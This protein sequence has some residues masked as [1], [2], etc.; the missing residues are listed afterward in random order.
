M[1][2]QNP[3][4]R[5]LPLA[6]AT[7]AL[8]LFTLGRTQAASWITN[9]PLTN[10]RYRQTTTLL[11]NGKVL[12]AG[13]T[14]ASVVTNTAELFDPAT[15]IWLPTGSLHSPRSDHTAALLQDGKVLVVGGR[16]GS[17]AAEL[18]S[19]E[20]YDPATGTWTATGPLGTRR[21]GHSATLLR[22]GKVLV[23]GGSYLFSGQVAYV[24][25]AEVYDPVTGNWT[26]TDAMATARS[27]HTMTL[28]PNGKVLVTGGS[29]SGVTLATAELFDP[30]TGDWT[31][32]GPLN[33]ARSSFTTT[34]LP[35]GQVLAAGGSGSSARPTSELYDPASGTWT[36]TGALTVPRGYHTA[37]L[38]PNGKILIA[39][40][41]VVVGSTV[42]FLSSA[43]FYDP[44]SG[45]W[46]ATTS[47]SEARRGH[48]ATLLA[49]GN[50]LVVGGFTQASSF[51][52]ST[53]LY[54]SANGSWINTSAL[55]VQRKDH[56][57]TLLPN[58]KVLV[59]GGD[60]PTIL[61]SAELFEPATGL[62]TV[63]TAMVTP[64][65]SHT[66]TLLPNGKLLVAGGRELPSAELYDPEGEGWTPT[67]AMN[68]KRMYHSAT[69]LT[70][71]KV[72]VAGG[73]NLAGGV[74]ST[75]ELY[76]PTT[77]TWTNTVAMNTNHASHTATLLLDGRV[78]IAGGDF[79]A[80]RPAASSSAELYDPAT[81]TWTSTGPLTMPH[82]QWHTTTLLPC[83][84]VLLTG[85][86][87]IADSFIP[88]AELYDPVSS[89][90]TKTSTMTIARGGHAAALLPDGRVLVMGG[91]TALTSNTTN[92]SELY[93]PATA[94]W[95]LAGPLTNSRRY[96]TATLLPDGRLLIAAGENRS[97]SHSG[98]TTVLANAELYDIGLGF[99]ASRQPQITSIDSPLP[100]GSG[101]AL[102]GSQF[103]GVSGSSGGNS[104]DSATDYPLVQL[105]SIESGQSTF[106]LS[107]N[108]ST[109]SF[110]SLPVWN[111]PPGWALATVFVNGI[112][113]T[114]SIVNLSVPTPT[115]TSLTNAK[116]LTDGAFQ[117][118]FTNNVGALFG[119]LA[120]TNPTLP[121]GNWT[122]LG[123]VTEVSPGHFQFADPQATNSPQRFYRLRSL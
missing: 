73:Y 63:T 111:F 121:L 39:G 80:A 70:N 35:T 107:T 6:L 123:G 102:T 92:S 53:E 97:G 68:T 83:G 14:S 16:S 15:G 108:W 109:N 96:H 29:G 99:S 59:T 117:F 50:L 94:S 85:G 36:L 122:A 11:Q 44:T 41:T 60:N 48:T 95:Q 64:R 113:S 46:T 8:S 76:D 18:S 119:V 54:D 103:R 77:G 57:A 12:V 118:S 72:L 90:W 74:L 88:I 17:G 65:S 27:L 52:S 25:S 79:R 61:S 10:A 1:K 71:R 100:L 106:L 30:A 82:G 58:G 9:G 20:L 87:S 26:T 31:E 49:N 120:A 78:L 81:G 116:R 101:L 62:W 86:L 84:K 91:A 98:L 43:E 38:L 93:D 33:T 75:A 51:L 13:G 3:K 105:R 110:T 34:L 5:S 7:L 69:L 56:T 42:T 4:T 28:L 45:E 47:M 55:E 19:A 115:E 114:S 66:A 89:T 104:Q 32:T 22:N 23:A 2:T 67:G 24:S 37:A 112:P 40:G 21:A